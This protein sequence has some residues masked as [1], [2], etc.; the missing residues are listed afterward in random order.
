[1]PDDSFTFISEMRPGETPWID[2]C[3]STQ[4]DHVIIND[5][6]VRY[7]LTCRDHIPLIINIGLD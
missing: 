7:D 5:M 4:G 3:I 6:Y 1:M 2:H